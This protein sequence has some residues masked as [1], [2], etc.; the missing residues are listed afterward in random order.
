MG[1][2]FYSSSSSQKSCWKRPISQGIKKWQAKPHKA[3]RPTGQSRRSAQLIVNWE[4]KGSFPNVLLRG[5]TAKKSSWCQIFPHSVLSKYPEKTREHFQLSLWDGLAPPTATRIHQLQC[6][7]PKDGFLIRGSRSPEIASYRQILYL[8]TPNSRTAR[9]TSFA[10]TMHFFRD[11]NNFCDTWHFTE[12]APDMIPLYHI[13]PES[14]V[15]DTIHF[16]ILDP[17]DRDGWG[18]ADKSIPW[19]FSSKMFVQDFKR[20]IMSFAVYRAKGNVSPDPKANLSHS[21]LQNLLC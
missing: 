11:V 5:E 18:R 17:R 3:S 21:V 2:L 12:E 10:F 1:K 14:L 9:N 13:Y 8:E 7:A 6:F 20:S 4:K 16:Y 15:S 19:F